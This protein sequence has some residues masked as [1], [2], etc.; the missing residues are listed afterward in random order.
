[1]ALGLG[2]GLGL[3]SV[4]WIGI[5]DRIRMTL[6]RWPSYTNLT[7][8]LSRYTGCAKMNF[9][10]QGFRRLSSDIHT[11]RQT[12][13]QTQPKLYTMPIATGQKYWLGYSTLSRSVERRRT[14][15]RPWLNLFTPRS[16][17]RVIVASRLS[18]DRSIFAVVQYSIVMVVLHGSQYSAQYSFIHSHCYLLC[19]CDVCHG[20]DLL[21]SP[22]N[23]SISQSV[24][25]ST[26]EVK[27]MF[28]ELPS[29]SS[30]AQTDKSSSLVRFRTRSPTI[31]CRRGF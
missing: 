7:S 16:L 14:R 26:P 6:T 3:G 22:H 29:T 19:D 18:A 11:Y 20:A 5:F 12:E 4:G 21:R 28:T 31:Q 15:H 27:Q 13:R 23:Q 10:R 17:L 1:M 9:L 30:G 25:W 2:L 24:H 8:I